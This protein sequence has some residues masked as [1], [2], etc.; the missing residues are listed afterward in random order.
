MT[1]RE[2]LRRLERN[3]EKLRK[4]HAR[5][6]ASFGARRVCCDDMVRTEE[7]AASRPLRAATVTVAWNGC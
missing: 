7:M 4:I 1:R 2:A 3:R 6:T 5:L